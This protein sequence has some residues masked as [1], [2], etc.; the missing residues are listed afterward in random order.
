MCLG[1][2]L[3]YGFPCSESYSILNAP[4]VVIGLTGITI[5]SRNVFGSIQQLHRNNLLSSFLLWFVFG[6]AHFYTSLGWIS[7]A[8]NVNHALF[9]WLIPLTNIGIPL[10][11]ACFYGIFGIVVLLLLHFIMRK[12][13]YNTCSMQ[14]GIMFSVLFAIFWVAMEVLRSYSILPFPWLLLGYSTSF[15]LE[16][17]QLASLITVWG[18]SFVVAFFCSLLACNST[19][20]KCE[21]FACT[22]MCCVFAG[23][24]L[25][26]SIQR[27]NVDTT[28]SEYVTFRVVQPNNSIENF[29]DQNGRIAA[30]QE[31]IFQTSH[32]KK[33]EVRDK[34]FQVESRHNVI[35]NTQTNYNV[36]YY[37]WP[38]SAL[39]I[40]LVELTDG[41]IQ[42][43]EDFAQTLPQQTGLIAGADLINLNKTP[44][45]TSNCIIVLNKTNHTIAT[46][47]I[48]KT[49]IYKKRILVPFGEYIPWRKVLNLLPT[50]VTF[51]NYDF[52]NGADVQENI[53]LNV[54]FTTHSNSSQT[55]RTY[56]Q[57]D[58]EHISAS[59][60]ICYEAT[61]PPPFSNQNNK[62]ADFLL[63]LTNDTWFGDSAGPYQHFAM[64]RM[65]AIE[66]KKPLVRVAN[67]GISAV[68][69][70]KGR[71]V[72]L[73][74]LNQSG[75]IDF[76]IHKQSRA[77]TNDNSN[78]QI[79]S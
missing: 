27:T 33:Y 74:P 23:G 6:F 40:T 77:H 8:L 22:M 52:Q 73:I 24:S 10:V 14:R 18:L 63:N 61:L 45:T 16:V 72:A 37:I 71:I 43:V 49:H 67:F 58:S 65:R 62:N 21:I 29:E 3:S 32:G 30:F 76:K 36:D 51:G 31:I 68:I 34:Y 20:Y 59:P 15:S 5:L 13:Q 19:K 70:E 47:H 75:I 44:N 48:Y 26:L 50:V 56:N 38:E 39:P 12:Q 11:I 4:C 57:M 69:D 7:N 9:A 1:F 53:K 46:S 60:S 41:N 25:R 79:S 28:D 42:G 66:N 55:L 78:H 54:A 2:I 64:A 17:M 35:S